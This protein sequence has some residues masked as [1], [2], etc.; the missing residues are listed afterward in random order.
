MPPGPLK[1]EFLSETKA[2]YIVDVFCQA[3]MKFCCTSN[4]YHEV[5]THEKT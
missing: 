3:R 5:I 4:F 1:R 2:K